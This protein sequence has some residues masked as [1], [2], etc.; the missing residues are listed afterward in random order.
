MGSVEYKPYPVK[1]LLVKMKD[2]AMLAVDLAYATMLFKDREIAN[3]VL[4]LE[5]EIDTHAYH[6]QMNAMLVARDADD[7]E[8]LQSLLQIAHISDKISDAAADIA[9]AVLEG[10]EL[11]PVILEGLKSMAEP[12]VAVRVSQ[13]SKLCRKKLIDIEMKSGLGV[14]LLAIRRGSEWIIDPKDEERIF[15]G[16][17]IIARGGSSGVQRFKDQSSDEGRQ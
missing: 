3:E 17:V 15:G 16:D 6:L 7:A 5:K 1:D 8:A 14:R 4:E 10:G 13:N 9:H 11:H 12:V 2:A